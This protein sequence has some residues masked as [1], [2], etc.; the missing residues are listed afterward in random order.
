[1]EGSELDVLGPVDYL[2]VE[3][4]AAKANFSGEMATQLGS[5]VDRELIRVLD[6]LLLRKGVDGSV[7]VAELNELAVTDVGELLALEANLAMLLAEEDV[8]A[9][10]AALEPGSVAAV[11]VYENSWAGPFASSVRR[12]G[13]QLVASGR[14][15]SQ[16]LL[17]AV[18]ADAQT[19]Q[20]GT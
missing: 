15:P 2:V 7:E 17:A 16:A 18:E 4:P 3:F 1:M 6:L 11:L 9:I 12:S 8:K 10:G 13:G 5:L 14:I 19:V 20:Q